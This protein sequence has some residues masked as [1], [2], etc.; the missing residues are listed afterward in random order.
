MPST[1]R[2]AIFAPTSILATAS[3][4]APVSVLTVFARTSALAR[5]SIS[6]WWWHTGPRRC[7][8]EHSDLLAAVSTAFY[9]IVSR[10]KGVVNYLRVGVSTALYI[11]TAALYA[12][13]YAFERACSTAQDKKVAWYSTRPR[14]NTAELNNA[15]G[16][17]D[18][19][20]VI[21]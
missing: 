5:T 7:Q 20:T 12:Y 4:L 3:V 15:S 10:R 19:P 8:K 21:T 13:S 6:L 18:Q 14:E 16:I 9:G 11:P 1:A 2:Y 17:L